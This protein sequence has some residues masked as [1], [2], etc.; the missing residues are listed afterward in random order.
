MHTIKKLYYKLSLNIVP[1]LQ[2]VILFSW[3]MNNK[4]N[5]KLN[6]IF[7]LNNAPKIGSNL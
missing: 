3:K 2:K 1:T 6:G 5:E 4:R 7:P